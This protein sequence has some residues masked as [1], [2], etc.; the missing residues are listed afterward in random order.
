MIVE[1]I[2][3]GITLTTIAAL[4]YTRWWIERSDRLV[5]QTEQANDALR[6]YHRRTADCALCGQNTNYLSVKAIGGEALEWSCPVCQGVYR[7]H[8]KKAS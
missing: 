5:A 7:T 1:S 2:A 3:F 8:V 6:P 4:R